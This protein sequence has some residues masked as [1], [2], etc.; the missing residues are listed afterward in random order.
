MYVACILYVS[1]G[2]TTT[3]SKEIDYTLR[4]WENGKQKIRQ[5]EGNEG[6]HTKIT[7]VHKFDSPYNYLSSFHGQSYGLKDIQNT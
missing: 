2:T 1:H 5:H 3:K 7:W 6:R 4:A